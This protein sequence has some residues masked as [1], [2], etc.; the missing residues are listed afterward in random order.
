VGKEEEGRRVA[1]T[2]RDIARRAGV[3]T[4]TVSRAL[5]GSDAVTTEVRERVLAVASELSYVPSRLP[6]NLRSKSVRILS[7][8]VGNVRNPY[9]PE[10]IGGAEEAAAKAGFSLLF[11]DSDE[12]AE[13]ESAILAQ[14]AVERVAGVAVAA[15]SGVTDGLRALL[16]VRIPVVAVDRRLPEVE[17]DTV[18]V[19]NEAAMYRGVRHLL[20]LGHRRIALVSGPMDVSAIRERHG[21]YVRALTEAGISPVPSLIRHADLRE[22]LARSG[23]EELLAAQPS[24]FVTV[25][26]LATVGALKALRHAGLKVPDDVSVLGFDDLL[27]G[28]LLDPPLTAIAQPTY[29]IGQKAIE[30][31]VRRIATPDVPVSDVVLDTEFIVRASTGPVRASRSSRGGGAGRDLVSATSHQQS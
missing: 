2:M 20:E 19:D 28:E 30:L 14:L 6:A 3:S 23:A 24:A 21:G 27:A 16:S 31:L 17:V 9:F 7:L 12:D 10:L 11:G 22:P 13:R 1:V 4:A 8:V 15:T 29:T 18:T 26:N 5:A 25:N